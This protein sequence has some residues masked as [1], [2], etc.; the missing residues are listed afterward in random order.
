[1][2]V[3]LKPDGA[4]AYYCHHCGVHGVVPVQESVKPVFSPMDD[5]VSYMNGRMISRRTLDL[6]GIKPVETYIRVDGQGTVR[7]AVAFPYPKGA[8]K[9]RSLKGKG[10]SWIG[11]SPE[12]FNIDRVDPT[13]PIYITEGEMDAVSLIEAGEPNAISPPNGAPNKVSGKQ[14]DPADD[15]SLACVWH[16]QKILAQC[17]KV[18]LATDQDGPGKALAEELARR[19]GR[20]KCWTVTWPEGCKDANDVLMKHGREAVLQCL[21]SAKPYPIDGLY[22]AE[23][24]FSGVYDLYNNGFAQGEKIGYGNVDE[25][26]SLVP[27]LLYVLTG[28]PGSGKSEWWD[29]VMVNLARQSGWKWGVC[30]FENPPNVH[31]MKLV[32][33]YVG[34]PMLPGHPNRM[35]QTELGQALA[36][37]H[38]HF[39]WID[40]SGGERATVTDILD[41]AASAVQ[42]HGIRGLIVDPYNYVERQGPTGGNNEPRETDQVVDLLR[43]IRKFS[44]AHSVASCIVAHPQKLQRDVQGNVYAPKGYDISG[45]AH[46]FNVPDFGITVHRPDRGSNLTNVLVWKARFK[47]LGQEGEATLSYDRLTGKYS[48]TIDPEMRAIQKDLEAQTSV[49]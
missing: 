39:F 10:F 17:P 2:A 21:Q 43:S 7:P 11:S 14:I 12:F 18:V 20:T 13:K 37:V 16:A 38:D 19:I 6:I 23:K 15:R 33:K 44:V 32:E 25:L 26:L 46:W 29:Q 31:I 40:N 8:Y 36:W 9:A 48:E 41:R 3:D 42:R 34:K 27:G 35:T 28:I 45:S 24:Y 30:S 1:M 47:W 49:H 5:M 22:P 4:I